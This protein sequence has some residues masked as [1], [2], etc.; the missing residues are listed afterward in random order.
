[1]TNI[2]TKINGYHHDFESSWH[3]RTPRRN[4]MDGPLACWHTL[5]TKNAPLPTVT[6]KQKSSSDRKSE[7]VCIT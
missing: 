3:P 7:F 5:V 1:M 2:N 6:Q 4:L